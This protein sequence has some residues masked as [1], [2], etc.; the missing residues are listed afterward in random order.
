M[1]AHPIGAGGSLE[2]LLF[3]FVLEFTDLPERLSSRLPT[4][5]QQQ[6]KDPESVHVFHSLALSMSPRIRE[7]TY[8]PTTRYVPYVRFEVP[9]DGAEPRGQPTLACAQAAYSADVAISATSRAGSW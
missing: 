8:V 3:E 4:P 6:G 5:P 7:T 2:T 9:A 1:G